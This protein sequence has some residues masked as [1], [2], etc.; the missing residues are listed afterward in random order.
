MWKFDFSYSID[1]C[2]SSRG[3]L[4]RAGVKELQPKKPTANSITAHTSKSHAQSLHQDL[5]ST[6]SPSIP[7][8]VSVQQI[9][10]NKSL[11]DI[12]HG[13]NTICSSFVHI[14]N[15]NYIE[16]ID[17]GSTPST[18]YPVTYSHHHQ[19]KL[20]PLRRHGYPLLITQFLLS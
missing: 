1:S 20:L 4:I 13:K 3:P 7:P 11:S 15:T 18:S 17:K 16:T 8:Q 19:G 5:V 12:S 2:M 10:A 6:S 9:T 14:S